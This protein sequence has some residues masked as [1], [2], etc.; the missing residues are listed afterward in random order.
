MA[1][2]KSTT[3]AILAEK[4]S[5]ARD[6]AA[7]L[8]ATG[9]GEGFLH[10]NGYV[11]TWAVGHL[12]ALA[13][14]HEI[15]PAWRVWRRDHLPMLPKEWPLVVYEQTRDQ[16]EV[17]R[18]IFNSP[19]V[20]SLVCATDA[21]REGE[22]IFRY[23][24][25]AA[26]CRKPFH[27]LWISSLTPDAIRKGFQKLRPGCDYDALA[28]A[29]RGRSRA[30]WLVG[31]NLS[32]AYSLSYGEDL[33]VGRVQTPTL[34]MVVERELAI[35]S[36]VPEDY[37]EV[38]ATF[39]PAGTPDDHH[40]QGTWFRER[41]KGGTDVETL[42]ES[43]RLAAD[44]EEASRIV[45]RARTGQAAVESIEAKTERM[46]PPLL[47]DLTELQRHANRL[48][49]FSAQQTLNL[50]QALYE[51][52]K[53]LSYP[54]TDSRHLSQDVA[55]TLLRVVRTIEAP[56][57]ESLAP[58][59]G[60]RP[61]GRRFVDDSKVTDH[62]AI[63]PT[64]TSPERTSLSSDE[65]KIYDMVC[66]RLLQ[67][68]HDDHIWSVTTVVTAIHNGEIRDC[69]HTSGKAVVQAGWKALDIAGPQK[70]RKGISGSEDRP[71]EQ[72]LPPGL[73]KGQPQDVVNAE[74]VK[75]QTR[76]P[77]RFTDA[78]LL[79]AMET[80]GKTLDEKELSDAMKETGLGTPATRAAIIEVLLK[81]DY[82]ARNGKNLEATEKGIRLI[83]VVHPEVKSPAMTGQWEA[84]LGRIQRGKAQLEPFL[85]GIEDYVREVV[86]KAGDHAAPPPPAPSP[87]K[88]A[89]VEIAG[90]LTDLLRR[91]FGYDSFRA[92]Q[93]VVC[94]AAIDGKDVLLVMPTGSGKSLCYQLPGI[95]R[96]GTTLVI[97]PLIALMEDQV[98]KLKQ[99]GFAVDRIHSGQ[100]R[101]TSRQACID[102][103]KGALQF[104]FIA[105]ERLRVAGF[106][107]MLAK[108]KPS[109]IAVDEAHCISQWG[110][111]FRPDYRM[112]GEYLPALRPAPVMALTATATPLVQDDI[113]TQLGLVNPPRFI[114][115][116]RRENIAIEVVEA[117]PSQRPYLVAE[118]LKDDERRPSIVYVPTRK[119]AGSLAADLARRFAAEAY[120][121]GLDA[122][123]RKRV[124]EE[125]LSGEIEVMVAT[126]AFGMGVDKPDVRTVIHT[127][128]PG[129]IEAYYQEIGRAGRDGLPSR[130]V[131]MH[132]YA[133]RYTHDFFFERDYPDAAVLETIFRR[134][135]QQP[136]EKAALLKK[137]RLS[138][139]VF[140]KALEKLWI[141][142]GALIDYAE[143]V[144]AG[145]VAWRRSYIA[146][147]EQ[148][149]A[150][151][152]EMIRYAETNQCR[153]S[154]LVRHFGDLA[155]SRTDCGICDF[156]A[157][158]SCVAQCF[159]EPTEAEHATLLRVVEALRQGQVRPTGRLYA[160]LFPRAEIARDNFE[161]V[162]GAMARAGLARL[163]DA[164]FEK[165]GRQIPY[166]TVKLT[167]AGVDLEEDT[168]I[169]FLMKDTVKAPAAAKR[170]RRKPAAKTRPAQPVVQHATPP[171]K[172]RAARAET[173]R[174][175]GALR[176]WRLAEARKRGVPAFRILTDKTLRAIAERRPATATELLAISG[177]GLS[178]IEKYGQRIY[179]IIE[180]AG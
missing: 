58:A 114:H 99:M 85:K 67:A 128:L 43:M 106:P 33:S 160:E 159:R 120:H 174:V 69:Y 25:E 45:E 175:E 131:L 112:L 70:S 140:D 97:S 64:T 139:D 1:E 94:Q 6:I 59:T 105:P 60:E 12:A 80:A 95:A 170:K 16:F 50:A 40:Y 28:D 162:L 14:P 3:V 5:V 42:R 2:S 17:V 31:M 13:E 71:T 172:R 72:D 101:A 115:G 22:L 37:L 90:S 88:A 10:G 164:A 56:Y 151:I 145:S 163:T 119:Q 84:Y 116:F 23:I 15:N 100:D 169:D 7:V 91:A 55:A 73:A 176:A 173:S 136:V 96:G 36:F 121:A 149:R 135:G 57:R 86:G 19:R 107:E 154:T 123:R 124:Q 92:N 134:L 74:S 142:G 150:Q 44:S 65:R 93:E 75:K 180:E 156:C 29:A 117:A 133:D 54:R 77:K 20:S 148:K 125:F 157:P 177:I 137:T 166:R 155:D 161:E 41:A 126:I 165:D 83:E 26:G 61:L 51:R 111:D 178:T 35:R 147:G 89:P 144:T 79:T 82:I 66:R 48:Y 18:K 146:H 49:G 130:A 4:P 87:V 171:K 39:H 153:M 47:Y 109:L 21:G 32:R 98:A 152:D 132:S 102:Y 113:C 24:Y 34:A 110:H 143:N 167:D 78:T 127:A 104:L 179:R 27:R 168:P 122:D 103:L 53:L 118:L 38:V 158:S 8:G 129:S 62:H 81:R 11:V 108:R 63:I 46:A 52:H 141:H 68:W 9:K 30:D 138:P 76:P